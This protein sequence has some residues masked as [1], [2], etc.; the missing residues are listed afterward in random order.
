MGAS[1]V[2]DLAQTEHEAITQS[3]GGNREVV[4]SEQRCSQVIFT[5]LKFKITSYIL[6]ACAR[7]QNAAPEE[8]KHLTRTYYQ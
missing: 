7:V 5:L 3:Q 2:L 8:L 1:A 6:A 4:G